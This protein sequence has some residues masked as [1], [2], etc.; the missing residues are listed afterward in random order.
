MK[1]LI[2][3]FQINWN[4]ILQLYPFIAQVKFLFDQIRNGVSWKVTVHISMPLFKIMQKNF[5]VVLQTL[6]NHT[7][8]ER[9]L[10]SA[11]ALVSVSA[12]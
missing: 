11:L 3:I 1:K 7:W 10:R 9:T 12:T 5:C 6:I 2:R 8:T 4:D